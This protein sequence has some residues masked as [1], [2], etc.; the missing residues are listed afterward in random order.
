MRNRDTGL[1]LIETS[2]DIYMVQ[3][4]ENDYK[5]LKTKAKKQSS[6]T[7]PRG[8]RVA[9][10]Q[11]ITGQ[12]TSRDENENIVQGIERP[13]SRLRYLLPPVRFLEDSGYLSLM[14]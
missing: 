6:K 9:V 3:C 2:Q 14:I 1:G 5:K 11:R 7:S 12:K 8:L 4:S 10:K 13:S